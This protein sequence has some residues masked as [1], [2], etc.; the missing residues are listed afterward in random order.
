MAHD[1]HPTN[2]NGDIMSDLHRDGTRNRAEGAIDK[3]KGRARNALGGLTGDTDEQLRG[4]G[5]ELRGKA[6][7]ALGRVQQGIDNALDDDDTPLDPNDT[8]RRR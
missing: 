5:E 7:D 6:K 4:K 3:V 8:T 2:I 1:H